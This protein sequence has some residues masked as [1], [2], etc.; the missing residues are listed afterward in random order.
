MNDIEIIDPMGDI[1]TKVA[2]SSDPDDDMAAYGGDS[3]RLYVEPDVNRIERKRSEKIGAIKSHAIEL[4]SALSPAMASLPMLELVLDL[5]QAGAF[6]T[7][8]PAP[9]SDIDNIRRIYQYA[10]TRIVA[11]QNATE[12][13]LDNYDPATDT[14]WP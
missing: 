12:T 14:N 8:F 1:I 10:K 3:W 5:H 4:I 2:G 13:Q 7:G 6:A 9:G 11:A